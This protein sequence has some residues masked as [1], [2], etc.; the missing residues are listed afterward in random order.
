VNYGGNTAKP[1]IIA[2]APLIMRG[3]KAS[4]DRRNKC[5]GTHQKQDRYCI[6]KKAEYIAAFNQKHYLLFLYTTS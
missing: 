4:L 3:V 6:G 2:E 5:S 1:T